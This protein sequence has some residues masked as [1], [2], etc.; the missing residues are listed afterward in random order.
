MPKKSVREIREQLA[1]EFD[2]I[3][4][5]LENS[6]I[7]KLEKFFIK[8]SNRALAK[9]ESLDIFKKE[10]LKKNSTDVINLKT[11]IQKFYKK[12]GKESIKHLN[13]EIKEIN[14][15]RTKFNL[16]NLN[17]GLRYRSEILAKKKLKDY[18]DTMIEKIKV[19][20]GTKVAK[21]DLIRTV[22][23][24]TKIYLNRNVT[25][26]AR[27]ESVTAVNQ[28]RLE[29]CTPSKI[30]KG[31]Q[32]LAVIDKRTTHICRSRNLMVLKKDDDRLPNFTP[33][34]H[35]GCRSLLSP[36]TIYETDLNFTDDTKIGG[37]PIKSF[38]KTS[39]DQQE[40]NQDNI[41]QQIKK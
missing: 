16:L 31:W 40:L 17:E 8:L 20:D 27:M 32:F 39:K 22:K 2:N 13:K 34:C 1:I 28:S 25:I 6:F 24:A 35:W 4:T 7:V 15:G 37:V 14:V 11:E 29:V 30:V 41:N 18:R 3:I 9:A 36:V 10:L 12:I 21:K 23:S 19:L 38:G 33:P 26:V 5:I